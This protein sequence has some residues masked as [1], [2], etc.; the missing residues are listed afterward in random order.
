MRDLLPELGE[1]WARGESVGLA[2]VVATWSS[3]PLPAGTAMTVTAGGEVRGSVSGG[4]VEADVIH[5]LEELRSTGG[6]PYVQRY[7]VSDDEA[8]AVGLTCGGTIEVFLEILGPEAAAELE[9]LRRE[10]DAG[11]RAAVATTVEHVVPDLVGRRLLL[12]PDRAVTGSLGWRRADDAVAVDGLG[13]LDGGRTATLTYGPDAERRGEGMRVLVSA[14]TTRP[15]LLVFGATDFAV[16][17]AHLGTFLGY[18]VTVCDARPVFLTPARFP[19]VE[20]VVD[21]PHDYLER[22]A[23]AGRLDSRTAICSLSHD[24]R[25]DLPLLE[26]ALR[27]EVGF[28]GA[29]GSRQVLAT[30]VEELRRAGLS[31]TEVARLHGPVGL[32]LG[33]RTPEETAVSIMAEIVAVRWGGSGLALGQTRG[34]IHHD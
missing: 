1:R 21:W 10:L 33:G 15:R 24:R 11:R 14:F 12:R 25:F 18:R 8:G 28:V 26:R 13:L 2:T 32:D 7:G 3:A 29:L 6:T 31:E 19:D 30:R 17:L 5:R 16:A 22:E 20:R 23:A 9:A 34:T 27:L 4:C